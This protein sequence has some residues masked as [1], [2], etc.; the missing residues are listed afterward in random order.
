MMANLSHLRALL[1]SSSEWHSHKFALCSHYLPGSSRR[2]WEP[3]VLCS[4][5][6]NYVRAQDPIHRHITAAREYIYTWWHLHSQKYVWLNTHTH[7]QAC[8]SIFVRICVEYYILQDPAITLTINWFGASVSIVSSR[9]QLGSPAALMPVIMHSSY[10]M[11]RSNG[12]N[13]WGFPHH[14]C[15]SGCDRR[16]RNC[17]KGMASADLWL[18]RQK[19]VTSKY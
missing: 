18:D 1:L 8:I 17:L 4:G 6:M 13:N 7:T 9:S 11:L 5:N 15:A 2:S 10:Y 14:G 3:P 19:D 16:W 12:C